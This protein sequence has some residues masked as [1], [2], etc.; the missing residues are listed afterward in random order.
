MWLSFQFQKDKNQ[1]GICEFETRS[2]LSNDALISSQFLPKGQVWKRVWKITWHFSGL[3]EDSDW[4]TGRHTPT[5][6][7][8]QEYPPPPSGVDYVLFSRRRKA[9]IP[10]LTNKHCYFWDNYRCKNLN[11]FFLPDWPE[12]QSWVRIIHM[13]FIFGRAIFVFPVCRH[14]PWFGK[15]RRLGVINEAEVRLS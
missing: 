12:C 7:S 3:K 4:R 11:F 15:Q 8:Q 6:N 14:F 9:L 13:C 1:L 10:F 5:K 2:N